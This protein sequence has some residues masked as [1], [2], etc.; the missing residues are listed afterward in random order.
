[1]LQ[2]R[3][4]LFPTDFSLPARQ[5]LPY[6][7]FLAEHFDADLRLLHAAVGAVTPASVAAAGAELQ[8]IVDEYG[9]PPL[10]LVPVVREGLFADAVVLDEAREHDIDL[11][12]LG[13]HGRRGAT[14]LLL[15]S[16][17]EQ[18]V[19]FAPCPALVVR[20]RPAG[21][22]MPMIERILVPVDFSEPAREALR[23]ACELAITYGA[24]LD[25]LHVFDHEMIDELVAAAGRETTLAPDA[26]RDHVLEGLRR[27]MEGEVARDIPFRVH[28]A[29][30]RP[31][32]RIAELAQT[33]EAGLIVIASHGM[34]SVGEVLLG[35]TAER[36]LRLADCPVFVC[37]ADGRSL[38]PDAR[39]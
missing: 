25:L 19:H 26:I 29:E 23:H 31:S 5:A 16:V 27:W 13:S 28:F 38:L 30:G 9:V 24:T 2:V 15:G 3:K 34:G 22:A 39:R 37:R 4:I 17:A 32:R 7:L 6:A 20:E 10:R 11:I 18:V 12:V 1:M 14:H 35:T 33:I 21:A 8:R 36:V